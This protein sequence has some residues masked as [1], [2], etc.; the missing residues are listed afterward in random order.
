[1]QIP[2]LSLRSINQ[3]FENSFK[4]KFNHFL[5]TGQYILG[6]EVETFEKNFAQYCE[7]QFCIG[8]ANGLDALEL[9]FIAAQYPPES[10]VIVPAN[11]YYAS[12]LSILNVG[13]KPVLCEPV[14]NTFLIDPNEVFKKITPKTKAILAVNLFGKACDFSKL[15]EIAKLNGLDILLDAAQSH[16]TLYLNS[17][18]M[19][20]V[21]AAAYSFY[22]SK[23]L[24]ALADAGAVVTDDSELY[25]RI[26][27]LRNYGS[28]KKYHF[29]YKGYNSRLS[30][31]QAGFLSIKLEQLDDEIKIRR[32]IAQYYI[33]HIKNETLILPPSDGIFEDT[34]HLFVIRTS[35]RDELRNY[36]TNNGIG[37]D[38]HYPIPPHKQLALAEYKDEYL[39]IT[40]KIHESVLSIPLNS[41][42]TK[43]EIDYIVEHLNKYKP[44]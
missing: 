15:S 22:P 24:G 14:E 19:L 35:N 39:P 44:L 33:K 43:T 8:V 18:N 17:K 3:K 16:G 9:I 38:I 20:G 11:T 25:Q 2:F 1:M 7:S 31:L 32:K 28:I 21:R 4:E 26:I 6:Q 30:E 5:K 10:E 34:W 36:L 12:I 13:L 23:N 42:L 37:T 29:E 27:S 40:E 41:A